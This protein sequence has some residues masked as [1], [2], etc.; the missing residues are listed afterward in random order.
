MLFLFLSGLLVATPPVAPIAADPDDESE[1]RAPTTEIVVTGQRLDA[2][3]AMVEPA[4]GASTYTLTNDAIE[5]RPGGETR[6]LGS[7]LLQV[8]GV[9]ADGQGRLVVRGAPGG[10]QYRLNNVILPD[11]VADFGENLSARLAD[12]TELITGALPAQYGLAAG[13]VINVTTKNG[14]Y[15]DGGG[16]AELYGGSHGTIEPAFEFATARGGTSLFASGSG[17]RSNIGLLGPDPSSDPLH[18]SS[19]ELEGFAFLDHVIDDRSRVSLI[20]GTSNE[21]L[22]VPGLPVAGA[23]AAAARHGDQRSANHYAIITYQRTT[24]QLTL[25]ASLSGL[26]SQNSVL[27]D[28]IRSI[29]ID[30]IARSRRQHRDSLG[31]QTGLAYEV[32]ESH[33]L[34]AGVIASADRERRTDKLAT[35]TTLNTDLAANRRLTVSAYVQDEWK[36]APHLTA[37]IGLRLDRVSGLSNP[38]QVGPRLSL[39]WAGP[40]GLTFHAGYARYFVAPSLG[41]ARI[42]ERD[43]YFS[44]GALRKTADFT[45]GIDSYIRFSRNLFDERQWVYGPIGDSFAYRRARS[46][47]IELLATYADGP[48]TAWANLAVARSVGRGISMGQSL[49]DA[50]Q[51]AEVTRRSVRTD[52]DQAVTASAGASRRFGPLLLSTDLLYGSGSPRTS[53]GGSINGARLPAHLTMDLAA[54]YHLKLIDAG[55]TDLRLDVKNATDHHYPLR[56]GTGLAAGAPQWATGRGIFVGIEQGF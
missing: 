20:L 19:Q 25:Q 55:A 4:L 28:E 34:R 22:Q 1:R 5:N 42:G 44:V 41:E 9:R 26:L 32:G 40:A 8:P 56:D 53:R 33:I 36:L 27:P 7:I 45:I 11:G 46:Q 16:Q 47:G 48:V 50:A 18:D 24:G 15:Q 31:T 39:V 23:V 10:V 21:R 29:A 51:L 30:G 2:A 13:G 38:T 35:L 43:D 49:F 37:N 52:L 6:N 12:R 17:R 14:L 3:R 54:V